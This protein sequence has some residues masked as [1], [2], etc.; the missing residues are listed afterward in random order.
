MSAATEL[1]SELAYESELELEGELEGE[2]E[3]THEL[4]NDV[5]LQPVNLQ[6]H[7]PLRL[8]EGRRSG[9]K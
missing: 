8:C 3:L 4:V 6:N 1:E 2:L 9:E 7:N 5:R